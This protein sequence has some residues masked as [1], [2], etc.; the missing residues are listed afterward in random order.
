MTNLDT[1]KE[2]KDKLYADIMD[3]LKAGDDEGLR[4]AMDSWQSDLETNLMQAH[5]DWEDSHDQQILAN[6]GIKPLTSTETKFWNGFINRVRNEAS[7]ATPQGVFEGL[8]EQLPETEY[9]SIVEEI[10]REHPLLAAINF[11]FTGAVVKWVVDNSPEDRATWHPLN[12]KIE[13]ELEGGPITTIDMTFAKLTA[14][15]FISLDM[16]DLGPTWLAAYAR[17]LLREATA[18]GTEYGVIC[19]NG[20]NEPIGMTRDLDAPFDKTTGYPKKTAI[21]VNSLDVETYSSILAQ[22]SI[23]DNGRSRKISEVLLV[24][25]PTDYFTKIFPSTVYMGLNGTYTRDVFPFPT[26]ITTST[27]L[28]PG[29]A[30]MGIASDYFFGI[31][32]NKGG[33]IEY[34]DEY[35]WL[36]DLRTYKTKLYGNGKATNNS[37]FVRLDISELERV[38]PLIATTEPPKVANLASL[39][40][41]GVNFDIAF[42]KLRLNYTAKTTAATA[43]IACVA[44]DGD[45]TIAITA[46]GESV[47]N[48]GTVTIANNKVTKIVVT[49]TNGDAQRVYTVDVTRGNPS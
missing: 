25:N 22:L 2:A 43:T 1:K 17:E 31:G 34:S 18:L 8:M 14:Y 20:V 27:A 13:K 24:V 9:V 40:L 15:M 42:D 46:N 36:E 7:S 37:S 29:E 44:K 30:V 28:D 33:V 19:G 12:T 16:L 41:S 21:K 6:R 3:A 45:A 23:K 38:V 5:K 35:K 26:N 10:K 4:A 39:S 47:D 32:S 48:N 49:V 11:R